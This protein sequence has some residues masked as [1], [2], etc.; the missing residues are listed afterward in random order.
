MCQGPRSTAGSGRAASRE[1]S[2]EPARFGFT[3]VLLTR[4]LHLA[5]RT[6]EFNRDDALPRD[7][8]YRFL[9]DHLDECR[10]LLAVALQAVRLVKRIGFDQAPDLVDALKAACYLP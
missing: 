2:S 10:V 9:R 6:Y 8:A 1:L 4:R 5:I 3:G 7:E